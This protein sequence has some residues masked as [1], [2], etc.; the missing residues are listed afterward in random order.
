MTQDAP[1]SPVE[2]NTASPA[3]LA[4]HQREQEALSPY[5]VIHEVEVPYD[6]KHEAMEW[7]YE[8]FGEREAMARALGQIINQTPEYNME[9]F[10]NSN[11]I[12]DGYFDPG[13]GRLIFQIK[14]HDS[15]VMLFKLI[16]GGASDYQ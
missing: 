7:L 12:W 4:G 5:R 3:T 9:G 10:L 2:D 6:Q 13:G 1:K 15:D 11:Y 14:D 16:F 8:H